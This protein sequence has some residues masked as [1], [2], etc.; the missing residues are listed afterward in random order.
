M[1]NLDPRKNKLC[2]V[3]GKLIYNTSFLC[4]FCNSCSTKDII[5]RLG[6]PMQG[7]KKTLQQMKKRLDWL[8][9]NPL[10]GNKNPRWKGGRKYD[11]QGY[12]LIYMP[13]HPRPSS[14]N[15][16]YEHRLVMETHINRLLKSTEIVHHINGIRDDNRINNLMLF[17]SN[18]EHKLHH[19]KLSKGINNA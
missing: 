16:I 18:R 6:H 8:K 3:C 11:G 9:K 4:N 10:I 19:I 15:Y 7:K 5:K 17:Y 14:K 12:V 1:N 2:P 13:K